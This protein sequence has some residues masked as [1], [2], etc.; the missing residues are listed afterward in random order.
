MVTK[1]KI[2]CKK[3]INNLKLLLLTVKLKTFIKALF[4]NEKIILLVKI[5]PQFTNISMIYI[6]II[7][8]NSWVCRMSL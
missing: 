7:Q 5:I 4:K 2:N 8:W 6:L 1:K 3:N